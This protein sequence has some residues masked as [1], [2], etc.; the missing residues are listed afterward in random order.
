MRIEK[1]Y[2]VAE[3]GEFLACS[4]YA[5]LVDYQC[6]TVTEAT[7]LRQRLSEYDAQFHVVKNN[8]LS[9]AIRE[10]DYPDL[11][12]WLRGPTAVISGG[13]NAA[14]VAK[15]LHGFHKERGK[16]TIKAG[17]L[18]QC[19]LSCKDIEVLA[20]LP[21]REV[22]Q[23]QFLGLLNA[24]AQQLLRALQAVPQ[25]IVNVLDAKARRD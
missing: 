1:K 19:I 17:I 4:D 6:I 20:S 7:D 15:A 22:L 18:D 13:Q 3:A 21:S 25:G 5:F 16:V 11:D 9:I 12:E 10:R 23:A 14:G 2:L 8:L 24:P